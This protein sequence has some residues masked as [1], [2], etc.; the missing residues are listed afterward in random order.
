MT[1]AKLYL[2]AHVDSELSARL[3]SLEREI[4]P[5]RASRTETTGIAWHLTLATLEGE[6]TEE[7]INHL[8]TLASKT[9]PLRLDFS[10]MGLFGQDIL[11]IAPTMSQALFELRQEVC[12]ILETCEADWVPHVTLVYR[13]PESIAQAISVISQ[14][15]PLGGQIESLSL[16]HFPPSERIVHFELGKV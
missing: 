3:Q 10:H 7:T 15:L 4:F 8:R 11:F 2:V 14:S 5:D 16:Y 6:I 1:P 9:K 12:R 13:R